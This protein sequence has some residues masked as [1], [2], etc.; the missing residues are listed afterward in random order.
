MKAMKIPN[1][2]RPTK[3]TEKTLNRLKAGFCYGLND[4]QA[5]LFAEIHPATLYKYERDNPEF[6]KLKEL[7][8]QNPI[9]YATEVL[10]NNL[11]D[12]P[13][14]ALKVL[15]KL[16]KKYKPNQTVDVRVDSFESILQKISEE[17]RGVDENSDDEGGTVEWLKMT[18][19]KTLTQKPTIS[20]T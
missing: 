9:K 2:G 3:M 20:T 18:H 12:K 16:S 17:G 10:F 15:E 19:I 8:R 7:L 1:I 4:Q 6:S 13:E 14:L 5:C 11:D